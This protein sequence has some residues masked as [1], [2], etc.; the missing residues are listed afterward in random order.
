MST[1]YPAVLP[2]VINQSLAVPQAQ[3]TAAYRRGSRTLL[4]LALGSFGLECYRLKL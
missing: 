1:C 3:D 2:V 4:A